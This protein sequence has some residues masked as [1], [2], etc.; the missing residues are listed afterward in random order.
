MIHLNILNSVFIKISAMIFRM[1]NHINK[2]RPSSG[3]TVSCSGE[4]PKNNYL[5]I[6]KQLLDYLRDLLACLF[7]F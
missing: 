6:Y 1:H 3:G 2:H 7:D 5:I 4:L